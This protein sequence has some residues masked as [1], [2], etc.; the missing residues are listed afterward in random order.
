MTGGKWYFVQ[1]RGVLCGK[2]RDFGRFSVFVGAGF[3]VR[4]FFYIAIYAEPAFNR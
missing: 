4:S 2:G 3:K 1:K